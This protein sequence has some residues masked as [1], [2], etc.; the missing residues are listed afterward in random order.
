MR[1]VMRPLEDSMRNAQRVAKSATGSIGASTKGDLEV[2]RREAAKMAAAIRRD[3]QKHNEDIVRDARQAAEKEAAAVIAAKKKVYQEEL[4]DFDRRLKASQRS[5]RAEDTDRRTL[6]R[7]IGRRALRNMGAAASYASHTGKDIVRGLGVDASISG[8]LQRGVELEKLAVQISNS[9]VNSVG[10][11]DGTGVKKRIS[12]DDITK[13]IKKT[14]D[15]YAFGRDE[16]GE[17]L[18]A[19]TGK[20]G[21]LRVAMASMDILGKSAKASG[22]NFTDMLDAAGAVSNAMGDVGDSEAEAEERA[23]RIAKVM[24]VWVHQGKQGAVEIS[25]LASQA[26]KM[27][28][29]TG[30]FGGDTDEMLMKFGALA[31]LSRAGGGAF[32]ASQAA[33][34]VA[35]LTNTL[36]TNARVTRFREFG[37][38]PF[39][40]EKAGKDA[41]KIK[42]PFAIIKASLVATGG[43]DPVDFK[44]MWMNILGARSAEALKTRY[45]EAYNTTKGTEKEKVQAGLASVDQKLKELMGVG[46]D[47][48]LSKIFDLDET[49]SLKLAM[50][51]T[52]SKAQL[53]QNSFDDIAA[54]AMRKL[55]P[56]LEKLVPVAQQ[57]GT[58]FGNMLTWVAENPGTA[59]TGAIVASIAKAGIEGA[60]AQ[61]IA[62]TITGSGGG[63]T[64]G[65]KGGAL[66]AA[67]TALGIIAAAVTIT[68]MGVELIDM[69]FKASEAADQG[70]DDAATKAAT[71]RANIVAKGASAEGMEKLRKQRAE[72]EEQ[73]AGAQRGKERFGLLTP[74]GIDGFSAAANFFDLGGVSGDQQEMEAALAKNEAKI[75]EQLQAN[76]AAMK[77]M[78]QKLGGTLS[79]N[80]LNMP[81]GGLGADSSGRGGGV[82]GLLSVPFKGMLTG[83]VE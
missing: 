50:D 21:Q 46:Q 37:I 48:D 17:G 43:K 35:S 14:A 32:T 30:S 71:D 36:K 42:D 19:F 47:K 22:T 20:T 66:G 3:K 68:A 34:S 73:L 58:A 78:A 26:D 63:G 77:A 56:A 49:E 7:D 53:V 10:A 70:A 28:A 52:A 81:A 64:G 41:G 39:Y 11:G 72:L 15:T 65:G 76:D 55:V 29:Q 25:H 60:I 82:Y 44:K 6:G 67:G 83:G 74:R 13:Q 69:G 33:G 9:A 8:T 31:Q 62:K 40:D 75:V 79:V 23:Q 1:T 12:P 51:I 27:A 80:V 59:I 54:D 38:D 5:M 18:A 16:V 57:L 24:K 2:V 61:G 4:K 45:S